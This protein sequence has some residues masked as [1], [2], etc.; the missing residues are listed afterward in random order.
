MQ[1]FASRAAS[2]RAAQVIVIMTK[3]FK[4]TLLAALFSLLISAAYAEQAPVSI[5]GKITEF[6]GYV[7][8]GLTVTARDNST[9]REYQAVSDDKGFF[10]FEGLEPGSYALESYRRESIRDANVVDNRIA[11][12]GPAQSQPG[13]SRCEAVR[14][15][16]CVRSS[17]A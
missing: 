5:R 4:S 10:S 2:K 9:G 3:L 1:T 11:R 17:G 6:R 8:Y 14:D 12:R 16:P 15:R 7:M 13:N